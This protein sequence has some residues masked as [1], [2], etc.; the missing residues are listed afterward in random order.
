MLKAL[1]GLTGLY[2]DMAEIQNALETSIGR[3][4]CM[5]G[6]GHCCEVNTPVCSTIEAF[7]AVSVLA[8]QGRLT[9]VLSVIEGWLLDRDPR[10]TIYEGLKTGV[11]SK[12]LLEERMILSG[13]QSPG[14]EH[15]GSQCPLLQADKGCMIHP[16]RPLVC[17]AFG[18][19]RSLDSWCPRPPGKGETQTQRIYMSDPKGLF[20]GA[21]T[22]WKHSLRPDLRI[23][24]FVPTLIFRAADQ[25]KFYKL[26]PQIASAKL[27]GSTTDTAIIW[28]EQVQALMRGVSPNALVND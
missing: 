19:L 11:L 8:G 16:A 24:G 20:R 12:K 25:A 3:D 26:V 1:T 15:H 17:R 2:D 4:I 23:Y 7:Q 18:V 22:A 13:S 6:C 28:E 21:V 9:K 27:I 5:S 10:L 14:S